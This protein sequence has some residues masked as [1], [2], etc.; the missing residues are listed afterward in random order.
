MVS[1]ANPEPELREMGMDE[2]TQLKLDRLKAEK[3]ALESA[4]SQAAGKIQRKRE[5]LTQTRRQL[6]GSPVPDLDN[7]KALLE[8]K[9]RDLALQKQLYTS[10]SLS[11]NPT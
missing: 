4:L 10:T 11:L 3:A 5:K 2:D 8:E 1:G 9:R 7:V 6:Q